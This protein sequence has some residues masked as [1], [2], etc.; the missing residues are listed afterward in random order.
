[1]RA[2][3]LAVLLLAGCASRA[4]VPDWQGNAHGALQA[5]VAATLNGETRVAEAEMA[6]ARSEIARTGQ[7]GLLARAELVLC[8]ARVASLDLDGCP[9][10]RALAVDAAPAEQAYAAYLYGAVA[11]AQQALLPPQHQRLAAGA[12]LSA[13]LQE[14]LARLLATAVLLRQGR[15]T[16]DDVATAVATASG[17]GWRRPLLA[18]LGAQLRGAEAAGDAVAA[19]RIRRRI[20]LVDGT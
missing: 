9:A 5:A 19:E 1:M 8:A 6:R 12:P 4:P 10:Y 2:A 20:A 18:W 17:Q 7:P 13:D 3:L 14:P 11:P 15:A 16:P